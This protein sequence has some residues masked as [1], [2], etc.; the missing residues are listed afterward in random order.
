MP[1]PRLATRYAKSLLGLAQERGEL[2][3]TYKDMQFL[4]SICKSNPDFVNLLRSPVVRSDKKDAII[5]AITSGRISK[6][7]ATFT[8]LL[9]SKGREED[10][11][12]IINAFITQYNGIN[13][14]QKVKLT[15]AVAIS[16]DVK[17]N[18][19]D[20]VKKSTG[21]DKI[22]MEAVVNPN[23]IGGFILEYNNN[24]VDASVS[25]DLK[26]ISKQFQNN[27]YI[28]NIR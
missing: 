12:E 6:L 26:D 11:P 3:T 4:Q 5:S 19:L 22:E 1:N 2:E 18:L 23:I 15:T 21:F 25:R 24:L 8:K 13:N 9:T 14:I 28:R 10:L 20:K 17:R 16:D 27:V 7:T